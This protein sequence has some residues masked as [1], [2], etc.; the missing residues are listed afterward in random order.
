MINPEYKKY[1]VQ[2]TSL[3]QN[4]ACILG[5]VTRTSSEKCLPGS[6]LSA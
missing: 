4:K 5:E 3:L 2:K 1:E 6:A